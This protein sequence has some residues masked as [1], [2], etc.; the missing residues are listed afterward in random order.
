[1]AR[2]PA[3]LTEDGVY[4]YTGYPDGA[5]MYPTTLKEARKALSPVNVALSKL[6]EYPESVTVSVHPDTGLIQLLNPNNRTEVW[7]NIYPDFAYAIMDEMALSNFQ[8]R[9]ADVEAWRSEFG[10][11]MGAL[12]GVAVPEAAGAKAIAGALG[13][14]GGIAWG[15]SV[16]ESD[17][18]R[19]DRCLDQAKLI[20]RRV[21]ESEN[22]VRVTV[23]TDVS[24]RISCVPF[25]FGARTWEAFSSEAVGR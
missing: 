6:R 4:D 21:G 3:R 10:G 23:G 11:A 1:M 22:W 24:G 16:T 25:E 12:F 7:L 20:L 15:Y 17:I 5:L 18:S 8:Q 9:L 13:G 19:M 14:L 2:F